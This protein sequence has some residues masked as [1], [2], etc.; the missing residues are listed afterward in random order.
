MVKYLWFFPVYIAGYVLVE[1]F[2]LS[3][4]YHVMHC[5]LDDIIPF[6]EYFVVPYYLWHILILAFTIYTLK[7]DKQ[8]FEKFFRF[9]IVCCFIVFEIFMFFPTCQNMRPEVFP[10][11][12]IF[13]DIVK[14]TYLLDTSTN[15]CPSM[16]VIG[17]FGQNT[18]LHA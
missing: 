11:D 18:L 6:C 1:R 7:N 5:A 8:R 3:T 4:E 2:P 9:L 10:R 12:N 17:C 14:I 15:V 16:H 13:T